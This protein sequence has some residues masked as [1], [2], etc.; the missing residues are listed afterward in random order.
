MK[1][2]FL[3]GTVVMVMLLVVGVVFF[4][5][6]KGKKNPP[7]KQSQNEE[8]MTE[9]TIED[10]PYV[11]LIPR[12]DG[13]EL[14]LE[15]SN[16]KDLS[17]IEY[18]LVYLSQGLSRGVVGSIEYQGEV[19][20]SR[21]ILLGSCSKNVC[22]YDE[23]VEEG[24]LTLRLRG[25]G[26]T[27][28]FTADFHLQKGAK[29]LTSVEGNFKLTSN[30]TGGAFYLTMNTIGLPKTIEGKV[31]SGPYGVFTSGPRV[32]KTGKV[33]LT[34]SEAKT[35]PKVYFWNGK[36]W[37]EKPAEYDTEKKTVSAPIDSLGVFV[38]DSLE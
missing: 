24:T 5:V 23:G 14:T 13:K 10:K 38:A 28:K 26:S 19:S 18:E 27:K 31:V 7:Q 17:V 20:V 3:I 2:Y 36:S 6:Q 11:V 30:I 4:F 37:I 33:E 34:L 21:K 9:A 12:E 16:L 25:P 1:K 15:I 22:K 29:E 35:S 32:M 8:I